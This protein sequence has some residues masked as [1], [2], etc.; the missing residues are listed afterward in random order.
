MMS[1]SINIMKEVPNTYCIVCKK[2]TG[3]INPRLGQ[4]KRGRLVLSSICPVCKNKKS[5][6]VKKSEG[7]GLLSM[8]GIKTPLSKIPGLNLIF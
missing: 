1:K 5:T 7:S 2:K 6:F 4:N 3:N 8:L